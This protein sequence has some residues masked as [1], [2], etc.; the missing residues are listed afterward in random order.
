MKKLEKTMKTLLTTAIVAAVTSIANAGDTG[1]INP[2]TIFGSG[3]ANGSFTINS[4]HGI[5]IGIRGKLRYNTAGN[6]SPTYNWD[7]VD[8]YSFAPSASNPPAGRGM[9]NF[10]WSVNSNVD[11]TGDNLSAFKYELAMFKVDADT[12]DI[13]QSLHWDMINGAD[14][15]N[16]FIG[17]DHAIGD[18]STLNDSGIEATSLS[19]YQDLINDN[20]VAQ[21]SWNYGFFDGPGTGPLEGMDLNAIGT[22]V[23]RIT[24]FDQSG[25]ELVSTSININIVPLPS[26]AFA[27]L[28]M[29]GLVGGVRVMRRR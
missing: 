2:D 18:N 7:G 14:P 11:G 28:G 9:F 4:D 6:P 15:T 13:S 12:G 16:G 26:A 20:N 21:N 23:V 22:Y 5:E 19:N 1:M 24:A 17:Y 10:D 25:A 8:T 3:N 27:G 29:L